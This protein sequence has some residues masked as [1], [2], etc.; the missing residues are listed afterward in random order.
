MLVK[1]EYDQ[2]IFTVDL[3]PA[4]RDEDTVSSI[5]SVDADREI[6][7]TDVTISNISR[8]DQSVSFKASGGENGGRYRIRVRFET[9]GTVEQRLE[10]QIGLEVRG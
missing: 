6:G 7:G 3:S 5:I 4:M 2:R 1:R 9:G 8:H 10:G